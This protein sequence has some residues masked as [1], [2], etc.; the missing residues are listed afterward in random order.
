MTG[1]ML[2]VKEYGIGSG[3]TKSE[4]REI[5]SNKEL[6]EFLL[7]KRKEY[8]EEEMQDILREEWNAEKYYA[9]G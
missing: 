3:L 9:K 2:S 5:A 7:Q 1:K 8:Y 4:K 6:K